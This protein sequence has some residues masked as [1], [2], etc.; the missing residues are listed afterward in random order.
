MIKE[1]YKRKCLFWAYGFKRLEFMTILP[2]SLAAGG[3][4]IGAVAE[5]S[6]LQIQTQ[7]QGRARHAENGTSLLK[8]QSSAPGTFL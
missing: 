8:S 3:H 2:G 7:P 6:H 1:S 5:N 4:C